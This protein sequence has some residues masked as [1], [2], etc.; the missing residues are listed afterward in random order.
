M[1]SAY[2]DKTLHV[3]YMQVIIKGIVKVI[4]R[5]NYLT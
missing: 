3:L 1:H 5:R 4:M 2:D